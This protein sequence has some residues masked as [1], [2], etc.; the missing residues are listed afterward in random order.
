MKSEIL[1][2]CIKLI[3]MH[4]SKGLEFPVVCIPGIGYIYAKPAQHT[5]RR[6]AAIV[7]GNDTGYR[8]T[9]SD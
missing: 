1:H 3:T 8:A 5:R 9:N 2:G 4:S 6:G 7:C